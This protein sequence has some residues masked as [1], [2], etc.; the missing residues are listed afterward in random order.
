[1]TTIDL[2]KQCIEMLETTKEEFNKPFLK[3][4]IVRLAGQ[5]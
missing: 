3:N 2:L 1:M 5:L 4:L